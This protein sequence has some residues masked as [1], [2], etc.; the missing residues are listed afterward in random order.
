MI[1]T[2]IHNITKELIKKIFMM[3]K[4]QQKQIAF[5]YVKSQS[6]NS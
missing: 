5:P 1:A 3:I 4:K 2:I 6:K